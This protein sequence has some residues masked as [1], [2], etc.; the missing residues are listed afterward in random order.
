MRKSAQHFRFGQEV[1]TAD[2]W[3]TLEVITEKDHT[4]SR[5]ITG[6]VVKTE[7]EDLSP[8]NE[9]IVWFENENAA[10]RIKSEYLFTTASEA[11]A[12]ILQ[13]IEHHR[14]RLNMYKVDF[15]EINK[16][17]LPKSNDMTLDAFNATNKLAK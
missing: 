12:T 14:I 3:P 15:F 4:T 9:V 1:F 17:R 6:L 2:P 13:V 11:I 16:S 10:T 7:G 5:I 8:G